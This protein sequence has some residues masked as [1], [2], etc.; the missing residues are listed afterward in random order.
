MLGS[1]PNRQALPSVS[2]PYAMIITGVGGTGV[3]TISAV[4]G[5]AAH[6]EGKGFGSIDMAGLAQKGGAVACHLRIAESSEQISAIRV[7]VGGADLVLGGDL[8]VTASNKVLESIKPDHT[9]VVVN[10]YEMT[11][12]DFTRDPLLDVPGQTLQQ[13]IQTASARVTLLRWTRTNMP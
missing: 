4:V 11:T 1:L 13:S 12:G 8:V 5:Q 2:D 10:T 3:V 6:I 9:A 7:G